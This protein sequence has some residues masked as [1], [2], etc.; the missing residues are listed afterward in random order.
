MQ[1]CSHFARKINCVVFDEVAAE[2]VKSR[3]GMCCSELASCYLFNLPVIAKHAT[4][5]LDSIPSSELLALFFFF[6]EPPDAWF[7]LD[8]RM[9]V[10]LLSNLIG[11]PSG[12]R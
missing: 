12:W 10:V 6:F 3:V 7:V 8:R 4:Q 2:A 9:N 5:L 11:R 1:L